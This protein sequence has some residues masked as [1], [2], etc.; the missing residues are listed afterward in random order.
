MRG[1]R[2]VGEATGRFL[3][4]ALATALGAPA[5]FLACRLPLDGLAPV[6]QEPGST[7][8]ATTDA[9]DPDP[10]GVDATAGS[11]VATDWDAARGNDATEASHASDAGD[12]NMLGDRKST[13]FDMDGSDASDTADGMPSRDTGTDVGDGD[14]GSRDAD[15]AGSVTPTFVQK[16]AATPQVPQITVTVPYTAVQRAGDLNVVV[17]GWNDSIAQIVS[18]SDTTGNGY[19]LALGTVYPGYFSQSIYYARNIAPAPGNA[20][21]VQFDVAAQFADVRIL[22]YAGLDAVNPFDVA[23]GA[24]GTLATASVGPVPTSA[25]G[26]LVAATTV[27]TST[28]GAGSGF[29]LRVL[30]APDGDLVEDRIVASAGSYVA[31]APLSAQGQWVMQIAAFRAAN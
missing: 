24:M 28:T 27:L 10:V 22:E 26:L 6:I 18:V 9:V 15:A 1:R 14:T 25:A 21:T 7:E 11:D 31:T 4:G 5:L 8:D 30:T 29:T 17:V 19:S 2:W 3:L 23:G 20:V 12:A 16:N 13:G